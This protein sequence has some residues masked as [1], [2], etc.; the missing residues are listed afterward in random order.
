M[1]WNSSKEYDLDKLKVGHTFTLYKKKWEIKEIGRYDWRMDNSSVEYKIVSGHQEAFL[2][3]EFYKGVYEV[4]YSEAVSIEDTRL[5]EAICT[6]EIVYENKLFQLDEKYSGDY[7][8]L[9]TSSPREN[10]E[11][12]LF[13]TGEEEL[14][15][16]ERWSDG[17]YEAFLGEELK[18]KKI[19]DI[20]EN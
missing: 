17:T 13:Y 11:C 15:T 19:K 2:E 16:I 6:E 20:K 5:I 3:V 7:K 14:L 4:T 9:T 1:F 10:L 8:N 18:A 12:F